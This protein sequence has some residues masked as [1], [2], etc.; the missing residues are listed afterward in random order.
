MRPCNPSVQSKK[1]KGDR[2]SPCRIP[3]EGMIIRFGSP[4]TSM[5]YEIDVTQSIISLIHLQPIFFITASRYDH[6]ILSYT[7]LISS[8]IAIKSSFLLC[9]CILWR[10]SKAT[11]T[12][13]KI[14]LLLVK[15]LWCSVIIFGRI[16][17]SLFSKTFEK[18]FYR[19]LHRL[20]GWNF[21]AN[22]GF[23]V[24]WIRVI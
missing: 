18:I 22:S 1:R 8:Y 14:S 15:A 10:D 7:L 11:K 19:T 6:S 21:E 17:F 24:F 12:L 5:E 3:L 20:M 23:F 4:L 13:S 16:R 9:F 2:G